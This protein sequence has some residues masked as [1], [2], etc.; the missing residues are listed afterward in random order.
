M[1]NPRYSCGRDREYV[2]GIFGGAPEFETPARLAYV[3]SGLAGKVN[4]ILEIVFQS[5]KILKIIFGR[6]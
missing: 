6:R 5:L 1:E 3:G 4:V 2:E